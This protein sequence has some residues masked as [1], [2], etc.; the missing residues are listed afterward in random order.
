MFDLSDR[1]SF[2]HVNVFLRE[3]GETKK[4]TKIFLIG[5]KLDLTRC[6]TFEEAQDLSM[7]HD[8]FYFESSC[9][10]PTQGEIPF[11]ILKIIA[12]KCKC[13]PV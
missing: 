11:K 3:I 4:N 12:E 7:V 10:D 2:T 9:K 6:V 1:N 13:V 8:S 5:N